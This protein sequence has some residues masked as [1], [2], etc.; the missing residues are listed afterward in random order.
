MGRPTPD[1]R[2][3][4]DQNAPKRQVFVFETFCSSMLADA[5]PSLRA[6]ATSKP[7][8]FTIGHH[9]AYL[10][11]AAATQ[12]KGT[13][14]A[15]W[16]ALRGDVAPYGWALNKIFLLVGV[17]AFVLFST[18]CLKISLHLHSTVEPSLRAPTP[19]TVW[20]GILEFSPPSSFVHSPR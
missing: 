7:S 6:S 15:R 4:R 2:L 9:L 16:P 17:C 8:S 19:M 5:T 18:D 13:T 10:S 3:K 14:K 12:Q 20:I 1:L 11:C